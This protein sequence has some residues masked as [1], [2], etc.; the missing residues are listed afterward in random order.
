MLSVFDDPF[1]VF[2]GSAWVVVCVCANMNTVI[3]EL[4]FHYNNLKNY[5]RKCIYYFYLNSISLVI[6]IN[7]CHMSLGTLADM[8]IYQC[9]KRMWQCQEWLAWFSV[10]KQ[11]FQFHAVGPW[12]T[13]TVYL[14][15][16]HIHETL[17]LW[18][19]WKP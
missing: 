14:W 4:F 2:L 16:G 3:K 10:I 11:N 19:K 1:H 13:L 7:L 8:S 15:L 18:S 17:Y 9:K 6:R 12:K 5:N